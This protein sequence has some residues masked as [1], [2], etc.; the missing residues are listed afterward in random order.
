MFPK[1]GKS[2]KADAADAPPPVP[3]AE[4]AKARR[5]RS[6]HARGRD[7]DPRAQRV[8]RGEPRRAE[9]APPA[10][11]RAV[12]G[13]GSRDVIAGPSMS[14]AGPAGLTVRN[15]PLK[16]EEPGA[17]KAVPPAFKDAW[18]DGVGAHANVRVGP[19]YKKTGKKLPPGP[20]STSRA[21]PRAVS[22]GRA[23]A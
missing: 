9:R 16:T 18:D 22:L 20:A 21:A 17:D 3:E 1:F 2:K 12:V 23:R 5:R 6:G 4:P 11:L 14:S 10:S 8:A 7:A 19:N 15:S 13:V